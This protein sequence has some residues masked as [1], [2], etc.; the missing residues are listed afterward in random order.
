VLYSVE[1]K[2]FNRPIKRTRAEVVSILESAL[3]SGGDDGFDDFV[4]VPVTDPDLEAVRLRCSNV[5][6]APKA[7][8]EDALREVLAELQAK[9]G[10][11]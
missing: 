9:A 2:L 7:V 8:F 1:M 3:I 4:S 11:S 10:S 5:T 6:F